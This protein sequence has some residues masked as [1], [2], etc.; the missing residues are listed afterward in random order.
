MKTLLF[1]YLLGISSLSNASAFSTYTQA[2]VTAHVV[3]ARACNT[4]YA[5]PIICRTTSYG[6]LHSGQWVNSWNML[7]LVPGSCSSSY[8]Y[9]NWPLYFMNGYG[10]SVCQIAF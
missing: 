9:A 1:A 4:G 8:V 7:Y 10:E 2:I 3:E 5:R 6:L